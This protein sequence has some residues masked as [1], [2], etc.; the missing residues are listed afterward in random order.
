MQEDHIPGHVFAKL[1]LIYDRVQKTDISVTTL[2][3]DNQLQNAVLQ[4]V[5]EKLKEFKSETKEAIEAL[6]KDNKHEIEA[7]TK[8]VAEIE[9]WQNRLIAVGSA[10]AGVFIFFGDAIKASIIKVFH[11]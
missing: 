5:A 10:V 1:D 4:D 7:L 2:K 3:G 9:K 11:G 6:K 8:R